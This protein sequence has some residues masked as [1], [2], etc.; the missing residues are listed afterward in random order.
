MS[1]KL[2]LVRYAPK[3]FTVLIYPRGL[4]LLCS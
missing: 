2:P 4:L 1:I 3:Y